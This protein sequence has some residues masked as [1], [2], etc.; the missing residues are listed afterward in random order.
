M[1][2]PAVWTEDEILRL[3]AVGQEEFLEL[4]FKRK[5]SLRNSDQ[6]KKEL[7][8]DISAFAN[9]I[10]GTLIYGIEEDPAPPHKAVK[11][12]PLDPRII[13]KEWLEQVINSGIQAHFWIENTFSRSV[14]HNFRRGCLCCNGSRRSSGGSRPAILQTL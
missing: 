8:K 14:Q 9:T 1:F 10:G 5:D 6:N 7:S 13:T 2:P 4:E 3:I 12:D 11:L